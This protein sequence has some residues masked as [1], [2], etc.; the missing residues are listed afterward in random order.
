MAWE[1]TTLQGQE[2]GVPD[3]WEQLIAEQTIQLYMGV[4]RGVCPPVYVSSTARGGV[5][6][7]FSRSQG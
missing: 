6:G 1:L 7:E 2:E 3:C 4:D 5:Q